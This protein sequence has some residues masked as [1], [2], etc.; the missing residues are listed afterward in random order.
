MTNSFSWQANITVTGEEETIQA[1]EQ[2]TTTNSAQLCEQLSQ[3]VQAECTVQEIPSS[4]YK[5]EV[6]Q[7]NEEQYDAS[8]HLVQLITSDFDGS[9]Y[10]FAL[11]LGSKVREYLKEVSP[12]YID[13]RVSSLDTEMHQLM[14]EVARHYARTGNWLENK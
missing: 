8:D 11:A 12:Q 1:I 4:S 3:A 13:S 14:T 10:A 6:E 9:L 2:L 7:I 5:I